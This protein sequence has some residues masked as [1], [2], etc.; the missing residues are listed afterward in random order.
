MMLQRCIHLRS[1]MEMYLTSD[2]N[3]KNIVITNEDWD[4]MQNVL[5]VLKP[6]NDASNLLSKLKFSTFG[7]TLVMYEVLM[8]VSLISL[9]FITNLT[10]IT[11]YLIENK[12]CSRT[13]CEAMANFARSSEENK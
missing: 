12:C 2:N 8:K 1:D 10:S 13:R 7:S 11:L 4:M 3:L 9:I 5:D 6:L